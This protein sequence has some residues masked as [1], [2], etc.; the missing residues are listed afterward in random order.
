MKK[1]ILLFGLLCAYLASYGA[2]F[3]VK[4]SVG[5]SEFLALPNAPMNGYI[6][7]ASWGCDNEN[8]SVEGSD[9]GAIVTI[10][11]YFTG[12]ATVESYYQYVYLYNGQYQVG[13]SI[14]YY[15][16]TCNGK[17]VSIS[18]TSI[19][20]N[21]GETHQLKLSGA[22]SR[23]APVWSSND[24]RVVQVNN[25]GLVTAVSA[26]CAT[27]ICDPII[28]PTIY[29]EVTV[30]AVKPKSIVI[31]PNEITIAEG[32]KQYL[33]V[34]FSP[35]GASSNLT[36]ASENTEI[37]TVSAGGYVTAIKAG[38][39]NIMVKTENN[40]SAKCKVTVVPA[41]TAVQ[42]PES[43][44]IL[45]GYDKILTPTLVPSNAVTTYKWSSSD[46]SVATVSTDG[47]VTAKVAGTVDITVTTANN[48]TA[49]CHVIVKPAPENLSRTI[50]DAKLSRIKNLINNTKKQY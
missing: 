44:E 33:N 45:E 37:A 21:A 50:L 23:Y 7:Q 18:E 13:S 38:T 29:C 47:K 41:P 42:L 9:V 43:I 26:G 1:V 49:T 5:E 4:L 16:I 19:T 40:L 30:K 32:A 6:S 22:N 35:T 24:T 14:A 27:I 2:V 3:Q 8:I 39:T 28:G 20:L 12:T 31:S 34:I 11:H 25:N 10:N 48:K 36:W 15:R 46:T 17:N